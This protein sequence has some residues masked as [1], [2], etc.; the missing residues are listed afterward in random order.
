MGRQVKPAT[1]PWPALHVVFIIRSF[2]FP[3]GMAATNRV[4]LLGRALTEQGVDVRV[5]C[6]RVSE[7]PGEVRNHQV[8]GTAD[9]VSF[10]YTPGSTVRSDSFM[11]RRWREARGYVRALLELYR[12]KARGSLDCVFLADGG[13]EKWYP[14]VYLLLRWLQHLGVPVITEL[15]ELPRMQAWLP[16]RLSGRLSHLAAVDGAVAISGWLSEWAA[17]EARRIGRRVDIVEIPIVVDTQEQVIASRP[18]NGQLFVYSASNAYMRDLAFVFRS[19]RMVWERFPEAE[20][21]VTGMRPRSVALVVDGENVRHAVDDGRL[22]I[23]GYLERSAL[24]AA[25]QKAAALLIPLHD[26]LR[27][28]A[29]FPSKVGEYLASGRP[30]VTTR[31]G[32]IERFLQDGDTAYIAAADDVAAFSD[33]MVAVLDDAQRAAAIGAAGRRAAEELFD[34]RSQGSRFTDLIVRVCRAP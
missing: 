10:I 4:R 11:V 19:M 25:Y 29:R 24:L 23:R 32:E 21:M 15:N 26:D 30:V 9:G 17:G 20:L 14:S 22:R 13:S 5:I 28:R 7:R 18:D 6:M 2:G 34:Y 16:T 33:K 3:E 1:G 8:A 12:L 31:V 27:S